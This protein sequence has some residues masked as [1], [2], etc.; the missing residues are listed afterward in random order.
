MSEIDAQPSNLETKKEEEK[1]KIEEEKDEGDDQKEDKITLDS[2]EI[3][4]AIAKITGMAK[5]GA[6]VDQLL[7]AVK[8]LI[9]S[10]GLTNEFR[11]YI[12][13]CGLFTPDRNIVKFWPQYEK[14]FLQLIAQD[15]KIGIRHLLQSIV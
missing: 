10:Y 7:D 3:L 9:V 14:A 8:I 5:D 4:E 12:L 15:G 6:T 2:E 11:Y 13:I 1:L